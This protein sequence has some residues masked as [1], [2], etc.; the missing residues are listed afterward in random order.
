MTVSTHR[1]LPSPPPPRPH[2]PAPAPWPVSLDPDDVTVARTALELGL[3]EVLVADWLW[4]GGELGRPLA[5][6]RAPGAG[7]G[8]GVC[9]WAQ[10]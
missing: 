4:R 9:P 5:R 6:R 3:S 7:L 1:R 10:R 2:P 8:E